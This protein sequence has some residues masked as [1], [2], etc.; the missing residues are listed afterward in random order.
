MAKLAEDWWNLGSRSELKEIEIASTLPCPSCGSHNY[1][2]KAHE[3]ELK[4]IGLKLSFYLFYCH[5]CGWMLPG[6]RELKVVGI[7]PYKAYDL[8]NMKLALG[9][10][11]TELQRSGLWQELMK[12][13]RLEASHVDNDRHFVTMDEVFDF[14]RDVVFN[15]RWVEHNQ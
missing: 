4:H 1:E 7:C 13:H 11:I 8:Q 6:T 9:K 5:D 2:K 10:I 15:V 3:Q 12:G 14:L